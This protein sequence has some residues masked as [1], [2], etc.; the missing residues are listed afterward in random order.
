MFIKRGDLQPIKIVDPEKAIDSNAE[1]KL[2]KV[3]QEIKDKSNKN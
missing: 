1:D 3:K 2:K